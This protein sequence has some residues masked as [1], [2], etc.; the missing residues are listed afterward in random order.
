[1]DEL[2]IGGTYQI[3]EVIYEGPCSAVY[4]GEH[5]LK[6][7]KVIIKMEENKRIGI[8]QYFFLAFIKL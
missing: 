3:K 1:M 8:N 4:I 7:T 2:L 6:G 5:R